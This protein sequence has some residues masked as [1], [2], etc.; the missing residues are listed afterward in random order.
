MTFPLSRVMMAARPHVKCIRVSSDVSELT[1]MHKDLGWT[2][3]DIR[4]TPVVRAA[5]NVYLEEIGRA[6]VHP[7]DSVLC[8]VFR[9][10]PVPSPTDPQGRRIAD[11][12][13]VCSLKHLERRFVSARFPYDCPPG[14]FHACLWFFLGAA[15]CVDA[16][17]PTDRPSDEAVNTALASELDRILAV[18]AGDGLGVDAVW[19][20][21]PRPSVEDTRLFHVQ[22]G[23][24]TL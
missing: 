4:P 11:P 1:K 3:R 9:V 20:P 5:R 17:P 2:P 13:T 6:W 23:V 14:T 19:Y 8:E 18:A 12:A 24:S 22:V 7:A 10:R 15:G 21:N 16:A